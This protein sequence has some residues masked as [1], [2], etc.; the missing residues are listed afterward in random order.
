M[1][2]DSLQIKLL[3]PGGFPVL[4]GTTPP[5]ADAP[6]DRVQRAATRLAERIGRLSL[7]GLIVYDVQDES[8]RTDEPRPFPFLPTRD[9]RDYAYRLTTLTGLPTVAYKCVASMSESAWPEWL[10][11]TAERFGVRSLALVGRASSRAGSAGLPVTRALQMAAGHAAGFALGGVAIPERHTPERSESRRL[12]QKGEAGCR[13]FVSQAVYNPD[14]VIAL[15]QDYAR[16]CREQELA[17]R[18]IVLTFTPCGRPETLQFLRWLGIAIPEPVAQ[19]ILTA[20][21]PLGESLRICSQSL[22]KILDA[23]VA[24]DV[25][26]GINVESVSIR[27]E[28]IEASIDL[29]ALLQ[30]V[31]G[32]TIG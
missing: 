31:S 26:L 6:E 25:P 17:P 19:A 15:C 20:E 2:E 1:N 27:K 22:R 5:R 29:C 10:D 21:S 32:G 30:A 24:D 14:A 3:Q 12:L 13:F 11:N 23:G 8:A 9:S 7:D 28:E 16:D 18:R 4:Y